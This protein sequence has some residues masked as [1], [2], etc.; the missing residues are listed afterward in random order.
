MA[1]QAAIRS[2]GAKVPPLPGSFS[3]AP[4]ARARRPHLAEPRALHQCHTDIEL[5]PR[6]CHCD[7][8]WKAWG[9]LESAAR[10]IPGR[11][12]AELLPTRSRNDSNLQHAIASPLG[13]WRLPI[14]CAGRHRQRDLPTAA[15]H[16]RG[17]APRGA[18][19][20][21]PVS[22]SALQLAETAVS[23]H[24]TGARASQERLARAT[25]SSKSCHGT[26]GATWL[27]GGGGV[28]QPLVSAEHPMPR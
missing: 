27:L 22:L 4:R 11:A 16:N 26:A 28:R 5:D 18:A 24:R 9:A 12:P 25:V 10:A 8:L 13:P 7:A 1:R 17:K 6:V 15:E 3:G 2:R 19:L 21:M 20:Q 14:V 23:L